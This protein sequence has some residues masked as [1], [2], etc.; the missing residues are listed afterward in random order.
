MRKVYNKKTNYNGAIC[1]DFKVV[2]NPSSLKEKELQ[3]KGYRL[4]SIY[5]LK[6]D[7]YNNGEPIQDGLFQVQEG[8]YLWDKIIIEGDG[9]GIEDEEEWGYIDV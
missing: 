4:A 9:L 5:E 8:V 6:A 3:F 7:L 1:D 2:D